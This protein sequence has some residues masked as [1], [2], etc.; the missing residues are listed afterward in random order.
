MKVEKYKLLPLKKGGAFETIFFKLS[1]IKLYCVQQ[2]NYVMV[3]ALQAS[4][5]SQWCS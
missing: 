2:W 3:N 4:Q 1:T 5:E